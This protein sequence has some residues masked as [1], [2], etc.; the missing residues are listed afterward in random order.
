MQ[1]RKV[2]TVEGYAAAF[3]TGLDGTLAGCL[4]AALFAVF[5]WFFAANSCFT[6]AAMASVSTL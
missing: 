2:R 1:L 4:G 6:F 3:L 5:A